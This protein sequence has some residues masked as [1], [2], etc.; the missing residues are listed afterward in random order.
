MARHATRTLL[1]R[2]ARP[3][4]RATRRARPGSAAPGRSSPARTRSNASRFSAPATVTTTSASARDRGK[5]ERQA[6]VRVQRRRRSA[7]TN[8]SVSSSAG[9]PGTA[10]RCDR[11]D[12]ARGARGRSAAR[13]ARASSYASRGLV[14]R[15]G[16]YIEWTARAARRRATPAAPCPRS[17]RDRR[18]A[19]SARRRRTRRPSAQSTA[20]PRS[21]RSTARRC[22]RP[23][24]RSIAALLRDQM[25]ERRGDVVDDLHGPRERHVCHSSR[26]WTARPSTSTN[27]RAGLA[28]APAPARPRL[29]RRVRGAGPARRAAADLGCGPGWHTAGLGDAGRRARCRRRDARPGRASTRP[30]RGASGRPR[31]PAVPRAARSAASWA[32]K[33]LHAHRRRARCR[34]RSPSCT[35]RL[36]VGGA[37]HVQVTSDRKQEN[38]DDHFPGRYFT[39]WPAERLRDVV[40]GA[41]F[42]D[43]RVRRRRRGVDRRRGDARAARCPT[44]SARACGCWSSA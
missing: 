25:R 14:D 6:R 17:S 10:T 30:A 24:A 22:R 21:A 35:A 34:W 43:R 1:P 38:A 37:L 41:G 33:S 15:P 2:P 5:R 20:A 28:G 18:R 4:R 13:R 7:T 32:H 8:R 44:P 40:E 42:D 27:A 9:R 12:R 23:T 26:S 3:G 29:A 39:W 19:P 31:A 36:Q 11:R 16:R